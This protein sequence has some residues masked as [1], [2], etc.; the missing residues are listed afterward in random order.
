MILRVPNWG[1]WVGI[2]SVL[3]CL[4][5]A[6][7]DR[8]DDGEGA[9]SVDRIEGEV[10]RQ[11]WGTSDQLWI[12]GGPRSPEPVAVESAVGIQP[13]P[14][15]NRLPVDNILRRSALDGWEAIQVPESA[16]L[17]SLHGSD[18]NV[19]MVGLDGSALSFDGATWTDHDVRAASGLEFQEA[20]EPCAEISLHS[21]FARAP[22]DVW[23]VGYIFPSAL[24]P[25]LIL[26]FDGAAWRR[27]AIDAPDGLFDIWASSASDAWAVG[28]SGLVFH[29]DG[30][31]WQR[32][33]G[34]TPHYLFS[35]LGTAAGDVWATGNTAVT[36]R[37]DGNEWALVEAGKSDASR[38]A[39][40]GNARDGLWALESTSDPSGEPRQSLVHWDGAAW[41][42]A[43][44][45]AREAAGMGDVWLTPDGQLWGAG[46]AIVRFR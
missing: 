26:H 8:S 3:G 19:W 38:R 45:S 6:E 12:L 11:I 35:V 13:C 14:S 22:D 46:E 39:L 34:K 30:E 32:K 9:I 31:R 42:E 4:G 28:S 44:S 2:S 36:T 41:R 27:D 18:G 25:G 5:Q 10:F 29:F 15:P 7:P 33:D 43:T 1:Y 21:V 17:T 16:A 23:A 40:A 20:R 24:G 37:F